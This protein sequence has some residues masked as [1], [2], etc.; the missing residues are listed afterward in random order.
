MQMKANRFVLQ[1]S[2]CL[3]LILSLLL[4]A[5]GATPE[6]TAAP[7]AQP[8]AAAPT[9][10]PTEP[11]APTAAP[12]E[13]P[14]AV[15]NV[16]TYAYPRGINEL[17]PSLVLSSENNVMWNVY[18]T[19]TFWDKEKGVIP[20]MAES[21]ES[22][23]D[24]TQWTFH[25]KPG[26]KC[27]DGTDFTADDVKFSYERTI[28]KGSLA[29]IFASL[30][31]VEVV[32]PLTVRLNLKYPFRW[33]A[34]AA[35]SWGAYLMCDSAADKEA[36]WYATGNDSGAGPYAIESYEAGQRII[37]SEFKDWSGEW[38]ENHFTKVVINIVE[39]AAVRTQSLVGGETDVAW[40]IPY[41]DFD[42]I[43]A[44]GNVTAS[45]TPAFQQMQWQLNSRKAPLN[46]VRVR[47]ALSYAFPYDQVQQGTYGGYGIV[48][49]GAVPRLMWT[50]PVETKVYNYDLEKARQL[51]ADAGV[52]EGTKVKLAVEAALTDY[53]RAAQLWQAE[54][55]KIGIDLQIEQISSGV[56]WGEV[57]NPDTEFDV[58]ELTMVIGFDSPN[59][60]L[61]SVYHSKWTWFP[62]SGFANPEFDALV[63]KALSEE[64]VDKAASDADYQ[65]AEQLL[66]DDAAAVFALDTPQDFA[67]ANTVQGFNVNPL[68][69]YCVYFWQMGRK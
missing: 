46:D 45:A 14:A 39:D 57:Y 10:A 6:P 5:C 4:A 31:T 19:L 47:Q 50:P 22:N 23:A 41:D 37:L 32:D 61:G 3:V 17:D 48:S 25:L 36:D 16:V 66:F 30:D 21:W 2:L 59:E 56:R 33:D 18:G 34:N 68:Y 63:E 26:M 40:G 64:A 7:A 49:K 51:L 53:V 35:N 54:L 55:A 8:T 58:M 15:E 13:P 65:A 27:H 44:A 9:A 60:Y 12:T 20:Y 29:Y 28:A 42:S 1:L 38:P 52:A 69:G 11:P 43:N 24:K 67:V 62:F